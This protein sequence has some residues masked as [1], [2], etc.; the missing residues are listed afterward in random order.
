MILPDEKCMMDVGDSW[1]KNLKSAKDGDREAIGKLLQPFWNVL[2]EQATSQIDENLQAKQ[3][4]SDLVQD[5][6][7]EANHCFESFR[8]STPAELH[9]WLRSILANNIRDSWRKYAQSEKRQVSREVSLR[10][11]V[12]LLE[13]R[14]GLRSSPLSEHEKQESKDVLQ[15]AIGNLPIDHA[16]VLRMKHWENL[17]FDEIAAKME[18]TKNS[19][20]YLWC[21][22]MEMLS[23]QLKANGD[24]SQ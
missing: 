13:N 20:R 1:A 4:P 22:A 21:Q 5:T 6:L 10:D 16:T 17:T 19:V 15:N 23:E 24:E 8:G 11:A 14:R 7:M 3:A 12:E 2:W 18:R 9:A